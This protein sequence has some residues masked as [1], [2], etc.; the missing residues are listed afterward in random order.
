MSVPAVSI[1]IPTFNASKFINR[2][3]N[4]ILRQTFENYEILVID[5]GST[6]NTLDILYQAASN[7]SNIIIS[8]EPDKGIYD[9]MNKGIDMAKGQWLYFLGSD[10][11]LYSND[12][13]QTVFS[14]DLTKVDV[15]YGDVW[16]EHLNDRYAGEF[17][18][19]KLTQ[20]FICHQSVFY[21]KSIFEKFGNY[22]LEYPVYAHI[23]IDIMAFC[24]PNIHWKY[25]NKIIAVYGAGGFSAVT[26]DYNFWNRAE[27]LLNS[28][29]GQ[30]VNKS[31]IY[32]TLLP[33]IKYDF[34]WNKIPLGIRILYYTRKLDTVKVM[35]KNY[36]NLIKPIYQAT[37]KKL[38]R[39]ERK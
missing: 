4:S 25:I 1:I 17:S 32:S 19:E 39:V 18:Y 5:G 2:A 21:N 38:I 8:S 16:N 36:V 22:S 23:V 20:G 14:Q 11:S 24:N 35:A 28:N 13:L 27:S 26:Y 9:A 30:H 6:D 12:V 37:L 29:L 31:A 10:D 15:V 7:N 33:I 34:G 3:L